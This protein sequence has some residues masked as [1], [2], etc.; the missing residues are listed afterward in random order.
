MSNKTN[1]SNVF[2]ISSFK[3]YIEIACSGFKTAMENN[4]TDKNFIMLFRGQDENWNL[5]PKIGR[6][7]PSNVLENEGKIFKEF[8]RL[9]YPY[10]NSNMNINDWDFLA[11]AQHHGLPTRLLDWTENP[12]AALWFAFNKQKTNDVNR[13]VWCFIVNNDEIVDTAEGT[14]FDQKISKIY[15]PNHITKRITAQNGWFTVHKLYKKENRFIPLNKQAR[16]HK[17]LIKCTFSK[18]LRTE[19]LTNLDQININH[20]SL[21]PDL[22][23]LGK[24][25]E[26]K[27]FK[28]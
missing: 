6:N 22:E 4:D 20:F 27:N 19:M 26:W 12:L 11:L 5:S 18:D 7:D 21:F 24:Y 28:Q 16:Y 25:L 1:S 2:S 23:G 10:L 3:D 17:R 13:V 8:Q 9:S 14:P 15:K